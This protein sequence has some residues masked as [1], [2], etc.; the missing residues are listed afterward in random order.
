MRQGFRLVYLRLGLA[1]TTRVSRI[2]GFEGKKEDK[3]VP[4]LGKWSLG[5]A[6][7]FQV[8]FRSPYKL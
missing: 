2:L 8:R 4:I 3:L 1:P 6:K 7:S 5:L